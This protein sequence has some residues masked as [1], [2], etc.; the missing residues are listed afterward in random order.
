MELMVVTAIL[1]ILS[2]MAIPSYMNYINRARQSEAI[3]ALMN[4]R[5]DQEIFWEENSRYAGT[6]GMLASFGN[7]PNPAT[8]STFYDTGPNQYRI[9]VNSADADGF[10][11]TAI[12]PFTGT[13]D[14][15]RLEVT[16]NT[17]DARPQVVHEG[18]F[19]FSIFKW[20]FE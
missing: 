12:R 5:M 19:H 2:A 10:E 13:F 14:R 1:A 4:A 8:A 9:R 20:I 15:V 11:I 3:M 6:I 7:D 17:L 16:A 18:A